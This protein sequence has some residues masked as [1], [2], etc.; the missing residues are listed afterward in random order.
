MG[1]TTL[2]EIHMLK[3]TITVIALSL[4]AFGA[5][6]QLPDAATAAA[7][8]FLQIATDAG[9]RLMAQ[10]SDEEVNTQSSDSS[11]LQNTA[12]T[13]PVVPEPETYALMAVGLAALGIA[14]RRRR[15]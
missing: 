11:Q 14:V 9:H 3:H 2:L 6:A 5:Q 10:A 8:S 12:I 13:I 7:G 15:G 1:S 4:A